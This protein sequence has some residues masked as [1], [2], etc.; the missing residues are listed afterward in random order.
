MRPQKRTLRRSRCG[1]RTSRALRMLTRPKPRSLSPEGTPRNLKRC[2]GC[3]AAGEARPRWPATLAS[4]SACRCPARW[5]KTSNGCAA[6]A[7]AGAACICWMA[8]APALTCSARAP[9]CCASRPRRAPRRPISPRTSACCWRRFPPA[10]P[11][12]RRTLAA[13]VADSRSERAA[14]ALAGLAARL[15]CTVGCPAPPPPELAR[16]HASA[17]AGPC[18]RAPR[19]AVGAR[20][21]LG[22]GARPGA[23]GRQAGRGGRARRRSVRDGGNARTGSRTARRPQS[24]GGFGL[25]TRLDSRALGP[26]RTRPKPSTAAG[27]CTTRTRW[28]WISVDL[29]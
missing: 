10:R 22:A 9:P 20:L 24:A 16:R 26:H 12:R 1:W 25:G 14:A 29:V 19:L 17:G 23:A 28:L 6:A 2:S 15:A 4:S 18:R 21:R 7:P 8:R 11:A 3:T 13:Q 27:N 5:R